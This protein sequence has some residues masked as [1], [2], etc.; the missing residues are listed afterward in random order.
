MSFATS[1]TVTSDTIRMGKLTRLLSTIP[2]IS[3]HIGLRR[4]KRIVIYDADGHLLTTI[5]TERGGCIE[6]HWE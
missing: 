1:T 5:N 6:V 4:I 3:N 2:F